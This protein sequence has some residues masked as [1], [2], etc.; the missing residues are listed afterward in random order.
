LPLY[1][2]R[3]MQ[4]LSVDVPVAIHQ[5]ALTR[6]KCFSGSTRIKTA[7]CRKTNRMVCRNLFR[8]ESKVPTRITTVR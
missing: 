1:W 2:D 8:N 6:R 4:K 7:S 3:P 5:T